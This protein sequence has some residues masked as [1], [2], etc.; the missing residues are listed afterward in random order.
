MHDNEKL[1]AELVEAVA[2]CER[3]R[4]ENADQPACTARLPEMLVSQSELKR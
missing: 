3:L 4:Q 2:E 1:K